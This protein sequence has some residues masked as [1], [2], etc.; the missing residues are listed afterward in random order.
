MVL[1][2]GNEPPGIYGYWDMFTWGGWF[3]LWIMAI[4]LNAFEDFLDKTMTAVAF[5]FYDTM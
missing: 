4:V 3:K 5:I 1:N 2:D